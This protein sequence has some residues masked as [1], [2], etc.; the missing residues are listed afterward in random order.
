LGGSAAELQAGFGVDGGLEV[1]PVDIVHFVE[2]VEVDGDFFG[3][4]LFDEY[5]DSGLEFLVIDAFREVIDGAFFVFD[6]E[7]VQE[8]GQEGSFVF[9][10]PA[11]EEG[12][13]GDVHA[14]A[15]EHIDHVL[16]AVGAGFTLE[17]DGSDFAG[18]GD[19]GECGLVE[20]FVVGEGGFDDF[21]GQGGRHE[22][23]EF[24][25]AEHESWG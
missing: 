10:E 12:G 22:T 5:L 7:G 18:V 14:G 20:L 24:V 9:H 6:A 17:E 4:V 11:A 19:G 3:G 15:T 8:G 1:G 21:P 23:E 2:G 16:V 13:G 25:G